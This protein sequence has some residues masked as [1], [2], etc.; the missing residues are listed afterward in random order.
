MNQRMEIWG[1]GSDFSLVLGKQS[2][3][4]EVFI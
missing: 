2:G 4:L 1:G 3:D